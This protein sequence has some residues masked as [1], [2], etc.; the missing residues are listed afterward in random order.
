[1]KI[2]SFV[3][4]VVLV[5]LWSVMPF[6]LIALSGEM[7]LV[8][9]GGPHLVQGST[10]YWDAI[11]LEARLEGNGWSV[12]YAPNLSYHGQRAYGL[13]I[14]SEHAVIVDADLSW[15]GR[16]AILAH[17]GGHTLQPI[18]AGTQEGD[19]FAEGVATVLLGDGIRDHARF[20]GGVRWT[21]LGVFLVEHRAIYRAAA[22]LND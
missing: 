2:K 10:R 19:C 7:F 22:V 3:L 20:L 16:Y 4:G 12:T 9:P 11:N 1:M 6:R 5:W 13:T 18:W 15:D 21:C 17:E 14:P 8:R